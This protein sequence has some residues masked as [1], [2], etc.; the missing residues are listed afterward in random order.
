MEQGHISLRREG[1]TWLAPAARFTLA[2]VLTAAQT[3]GG[4]AP[5]AL[6]LVSAAGGGAAGA[7]AFAGTAAGALVFLDF[8]R[9]LPHLAVAVLILTAAAAFR[10]SRLLGTPGALAATGGF[11]P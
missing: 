3:A 5:F 1:M 10:G 7:A 8:H 2:A 11:Y 4:S 6:G 9:A